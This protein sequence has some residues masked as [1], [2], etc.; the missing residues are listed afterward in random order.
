MVEWLFKKIKE[1]I[2]KNVDK[3]N[4]RLLIYNSMGKSSKIYRIFKTLSSYK[5]I[6]KE[7]G[8]KDSEGIANELFVNNE[9]EFSKKEWTEF[10]ELLQNYEFWSLPVTIDRTGFDGTSWVLEGMNPYG[11][12]CTNRENHVVARWQP[13]DTMKEMKLNYKLIE[14]NEK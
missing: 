9:T 4:Y 14:L 2:L 12:E 3:E 5:L 7:F 6:Y 10:Q 13:I 8:N 1:P 11:N